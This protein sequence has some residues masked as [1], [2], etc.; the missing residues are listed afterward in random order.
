[1]VQEGYAVVGTPDD[2]AAQLERLWDKV[3]EFGTYL[4]LGHNW[5]DFEATKKSYELFARHALPKFSHRNRAREAS[6]VHVQ[7]G[8]NTLI[9][10]TQAAIAHEKEKYARTKVQ[11]STQSAQSTSSSK[12]G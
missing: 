2:A 6:L 8:A 10:E 5:A 3:G 4:F 7:S 1:M 9:K 12:S 11:Q